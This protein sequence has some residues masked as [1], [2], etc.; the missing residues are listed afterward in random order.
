MK[1]LL[2]LVI[3][4]LFSHSIFSQDEI[5]NANRSGLTL[6]NAEVG[7]GLQFIIPNGEFQKNTGSIPVGIGGH[8]YHKIGSKF[9][10]G[11]EL[12]VAC[13]SH[14][15][16]EV[17]L[18]N[19]EKGTLYEDENMW[20]LMIGGRFNFIGNSKFRTYT[21][22][23]A[24]TNTFYTTVTGNRC[25]GALKDYENMQTHGTS[26]VS[27]IGL[28]FNLDPKAILKNEAGSTWISLRGAYVAGTGVN[29]RNAPE[30]VSLNPLDSHIYNST[31]GYF[32][33]GISASW[34]IR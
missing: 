28:G 34:Q 3:I 15:E 7:I 1:G 16:Y 21:E 8:Y 19:G 17:D 25:D 18:D 32:E 9:M 11:G 13:M 22:V 30:S 31:L 12:S 26:F 33:I 10:L 5:S 20:G 24:G 23:R 29:Y 6:P 4:G 2:T 27:S 14:A